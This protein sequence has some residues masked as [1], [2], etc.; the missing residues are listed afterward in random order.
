MLTLDQQR[1]RAIQRRKL[2]QAIAKTETQIAAKRD[3]DAGRSVSTVPEFECFYR[4]IIG[5]RSRFL[6]RSTCYRLPKRLDHGHGGRLLR[7]TR[8]VRQSNYHMVFSLPASGP[9]PCLQYPADLLPGEVPHPVVRDVSSATPPVIQP[10][11]IP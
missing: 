8:S 5:R 2:M 10:A 1:Q 7:P 4:I 11:G 9:I 3:A 6:P